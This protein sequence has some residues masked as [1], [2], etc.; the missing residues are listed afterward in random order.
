MRGG[1][2]IRRQNDQAVPQVG[3]LPHGVGQPALVEGLQE[4]VPDHRMGFLE[5]VE[6]QH[7]ERL[8]AH[9]ADQ[10]ICFECRSAALPENLAHR[11]VGLKLA[12]VE[13]DQALG[14]TEQKFRYGFGELGLAGAGRPGEQKD[15]DRLARIVEAGLEHGDAIDDRTDRLVLAEHPRIEEFAH[16]REVELLP[17]VENRQRQAGELRQRFQNLA[18]RDDVV[19][20]LSANHGELEHQQ[21]RARQAH[22]CP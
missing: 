16:C 10:R 8:L 11:F 14:R 5:L 21:H 18:R 17:G 13:P 12:H 6:Q 4:Q 2:E 3:G 9:A 19:L 22:C 20:F 1:A 15:A 7:R